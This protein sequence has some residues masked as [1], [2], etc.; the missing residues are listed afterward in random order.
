[1]AQF[2]EKRAYRRER[3]LAAEV[4]E[5]EQMFAPALYCAKVATKLA[6]VNS[7]QNAIVSFG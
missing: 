6:V 3:R 4:G 7:D 2:Y 1:M 5:F